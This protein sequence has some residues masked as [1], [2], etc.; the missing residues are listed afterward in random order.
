M[1]MSLQ[2]H[3]GLLHVTDLVGSGMAAQLQLSTCYGSNNKGEGCPDCV[4]LDSARL[5]TQC[6]PLEPN[7]V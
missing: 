6:S 2:N 5:E 7:S 3:I 4:W 1:E